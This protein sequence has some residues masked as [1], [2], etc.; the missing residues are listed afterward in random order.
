MGV[1]KGGSAAGARLAAPSWRRQTVGELLRLPGQSREKP[2]ARGALGKAGAK[3]RV[4]AR[5]L[6][7][8]AIEQLFVLE[9][10]GLVFGEQLAGAALGLLPD[11][12]ARGDL[13]DFRLRRD[14]GER[15]MAAPAQHDDQRI[16]QIGADVLRPDAEH[17]GDEVRA[18]RSG[19]GNV[20]A[21]GKGG[22]RSDGLRDEAVLA[23]RFIERRRRFSRLFADSD[24]GARL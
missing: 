1:A 18:L 8:I 10:L 9:A 4:A 13:R 17:R 23:Q 21:P 12:L 15:D 14:G 20:G 19:D 7:R 6:G 2:F 24:E 3:G 16:G 22:V 11:F 5:L